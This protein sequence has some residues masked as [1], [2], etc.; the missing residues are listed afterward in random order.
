MARLK[1][2]YGIDLGTT[3]SAICRM[4][5]GKPIIKKSD[6]Q[7]DITPSCV[8]VT[9]RR[10]IKVGDTAYNDLKSDK[11][12]STK[13]WK[14][15]SSNTFNEFKR[16]M[17]NNAIYHSSYME[18]DYT[19][20]ELSSEVL[21]TLK[22]FII[23]ET[24]SSA[25]I[26]VP[27]MFSANQKAATMKAA[28]LA[29]FEHCELLQEPIAASMA[30]GIESAQKQG[31]WMVFDFGGG[32]F[33][34]ALVKVEDGIM[35]VFD[36]AGDNYLGGKNL[37]EAIVDK[38]IIPY[39]HENFKIDKI[40]S[41]KN[42][43][44]ILRDAMKTFA[45]GVKNQ[46]S[47]KDKEDII[48]NLGELGA[49]DEGTELELDLT[50]T[51]K[52]AYEA[53]EPLFQK[54]VDICKDL[55]QRNNLSGSQ[56]DKL[57]LVGG[58]THSPLIRQMLKEQITENVDASVDPMTVVAS[59]AAL[60]ASTIDTKSQIVTP[61][62]TVVLEVGYEA[63]S[64]EPSEWVTVSLNRN[65]CE[66]ELPS[67]V[68]VELVRGDK[69][70]SSGKI[71][72]TASENGD[73]IEAQLIEGKPNVFS[74]IAYD[75]KG[76]RLPCFPSEIT[77]IQG[78]KIGSAPLPY[79]IGIEM[80]DTDKGKAVLRGLKGLEKNMHLPAIGT[81]NGLKTAKDLRPGV[82][83][84]FIKIPVYQF[85]DIAEGK[86]AAL[87][88]YITDVIITGDEIDALLPAGSDLDITLKA[89][90]SEMMT[91]EVYFP[92]IDCTVTKQ[93][94]LE[95]RHEA[96]TDT[97]LKEGIV[98][99]NNTLLKLQVEGCCDIQK[100]S[101]QLQMVQSELE[102]GSQNKQILEHLKEVLCQVEDLES[103]SEW[104]RLEKE[105]RRMFTELEKDQNKYGNAQ[106]AEIINQLK[107]VV[108]Q[109]IRS[110]DVKMGKE[111]LDQIKALD[112][113]LAQVEYLGVWIYNWYQN[114]DNNPWKDQ[115]RARQLVNRGMEILNDNPTADKLIPIVGQLLDLLPNNAR[116][117]GS[118]DLVHG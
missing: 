73:V 86:F 99:A 28:K 109:V 69:S 118:D 117:D 103:G 116:P 7:A 36:T 23:N 108:D 75:A 8:S 2:D 72:I 67:R 40:L 62:G 80:Y 78:S 29:G 15:S 68:F 6:N 24:L 92:K 26:T 33:D 32:T 52:Q 106:S 91:M 42:K 21:K 113:R 41:D 115:S 55:L 13:T 76:N 57:I 44:E 88:E 16:E 60:Y 85:K 25:V 19:P 51:Q 11:R 49:D 94:D 5:S 97:Y 89:D 18:Q 107:I 82:S 39:L 93:V 81:R 102:N 63:T 64:V 84:D 30:Y 43:K 20:E 1:I 17:G 77:I 59:G 38:I 111:L 112:Y 27:A 110:K 70:W 79:N 48:S 46:L 114:F 56:L 104:D 35:Q 22:S 87:S 95:K 31:L 58:P 83:A 98:K 50:V 96:V 105:V 71:D 54:A 74:V 61:S 4:E 12:S 65:K 3:N 53:M 14:K 45:E 47:F 9:K 66:G 37:D 34:T 101:E 10:S 90:K 100:I